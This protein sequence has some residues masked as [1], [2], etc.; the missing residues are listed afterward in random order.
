MTALNISKTRVARQFLAILSATCLLASSLPV[1]ADNPQRLT[2]EESFVGIHFDF[3]AGEA[4]QNIGSNTTPEMVQRILDMVH[5]DF[6]Q[7]DSKGH[8]GWS[9]YP[10][11]VGNPSPGVVADSLKVW[12]EITARNGVALY[13]HYSGVW[14]ETAVARH[15]EWAVVDGAGNK[16]TQKTSVFSEYKDKLLVPQLLEFALDYGIDGVWVDGECWATQIDYGDAAKEAFKAAT[17]CAEVPTDPSQDD[18]QEW[19]NFHREAFRE[20]LRSYVDEVKAKAPNYQ[21]ASNWAFTDHMA[22][23]A[24]ANVDFISG[25]Y[26][27][28]NSV[29]SA[30]YS[31]RLMANQDKPWD[32]MAWSFASQNGWVPKTGIQLSREAACVLAQG[33]AFQAYYTQE[34]D[35][36]LNVSKLDTMATAAKFCRA[37]QELCQHSA[38]FPQVA[39]FCPTATHYFNISSQGEG[40]FPMITCQRPILCR[41]LEMNYAVDILTDS[42]LSRRIDEFPVVIFYRGDR[43]SD[44]LKAKVKEYVSNGGSVVAIGNESVDELKN[45]VGDFEKVDSLSRDD[46]WFLDFCRFGEGTMVMFPTPVG[47]PQEFIDANG[48]TFGEFLQTAMKRAFPKPIVEFDERQPLDVSVRRSQTGL[49]TIHFVNVSGP[50]ETEPVVENIDPVVN[51]KT[52]I[53]LPERP[54]SLRLEPSGVDLDFE[55]QN[56]AA[57][58]TLPSIQIHEI[59]VVK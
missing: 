7:V 4:D 16:S 22:E 23:P 27:P 5:P 41:L 13:T 57:V 46:V 58:V 2:R 15:P 12:R 50:H 45:A 47:S 33:G 10:T 51:V 25:D 18:W 24:T 9:S 48:S 32:L 28:N 11:K 56:S 42:A 19:C 29:N 43:W 37:R 39:L 14:D 59:L 55:W 52:T 20:Y 49:L 3:H 1:H 40:L 17:G 31:S 21:I 30:R 53:N 44:D 36:S 38:C 8:P 35:G 34:R 6:I 26:S 54:T